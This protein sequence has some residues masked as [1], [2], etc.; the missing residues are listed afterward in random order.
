MS[1][2]GS[3]AQEAVSE[4]K[5]IDCQRA[6]EAVMNLLRLDIKPRDI[7]TKAAI[8]NAIKVLSALGGSTKGVQH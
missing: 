3:S 5:K 1:L 2:P 8:E 7:M 6:G 4:D